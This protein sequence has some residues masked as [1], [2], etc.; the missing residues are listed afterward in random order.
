MSTSEKVIRVDPPRPSSD[1]S[2][3]QT[4]EIP[5]RQNRRLTREA[6]ISHERAAEA[7]HR[8]IHS[9]FGQQPYARIHIPVDQD[10]DDVVICEYIEQQIEKELGL[11]K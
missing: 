10:D 9:H 3:A 2:A 4:I 5:P 7:A 8:L 6:N 1:P 11:R